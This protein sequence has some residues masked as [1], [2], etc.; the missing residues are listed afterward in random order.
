M[1]W[2]L[3]PQ[4]NVA[5]TVPQNFLAFE[6]SIALPEWWYDIITGL[7]DP[8][9]KNGHIEVWDRPGLGVDFI[10]KEAMKYLNEEDKKFFD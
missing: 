5:A 9:V 6:Y 7:P 3:M 10:V 4:V 8:L 1:I 2:K